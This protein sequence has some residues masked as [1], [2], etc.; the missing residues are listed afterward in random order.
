MKLKTLTFALPAS[1]VTG[2]LIIGYSIERHRQA[3]LCSVITS[4][5]PKLLEAVV[6]GHQALDHIEA[7]AQ[8][9]EQ[10][11]FPHKIKTAARYG[12]ALEKAFGV[13]CFHYASEQEYLRKQKPN[14]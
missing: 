8:D 2:A 9:E 10:K 6:I 5:Y 11:E 3:Q 1:I 12:E 14:P 4:T 13:S 7:R